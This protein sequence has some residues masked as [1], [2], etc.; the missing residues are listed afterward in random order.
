LDAQVQ[1]RSLN[2]VRSKRRNLENGGKNSAE[3]HV[4]KQVMQQALQRDMCFLGG[5]CPEEAKAYLE[6]AQGDMEEA[7]R[8]YR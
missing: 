1:K 6:L 4:T 7:M 5:G 8:M 3:A 2:K